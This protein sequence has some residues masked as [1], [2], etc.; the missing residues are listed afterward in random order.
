MNIKYLFLGNTKDSSIIGDFPN[1]PSA[2]WVSDT[3]NIFENYLDGNLTGKINQ[4]NKINQKW[5]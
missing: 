1:R 3:T 4:R 5:R 2:N